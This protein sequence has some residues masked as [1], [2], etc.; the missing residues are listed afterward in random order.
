VVSAT[1]GV[2]VALP[3]TVPAVLGVIVAEQLAVV[4]LTVV[5]VHGV[6]LNVPV[7]V[8]VFVNATV[9]AGVDAVPADVSFTNAVHVTS[10]PTDTDVG[11]HA[12]AVEVVLFV[13]LTA[14]LAP[15]LVL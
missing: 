8:P 3:I 2:Y 5:R 6:P 7:A 14:A 1:E 11:E 15:L 4:A 13:T 12:M 9:P 10:C